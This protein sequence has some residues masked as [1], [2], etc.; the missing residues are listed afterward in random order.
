MIQSQIPITPEQVNAVTQRLSFALTAPSYVLPQIRE[1]KTSGGY[2]SYGLDNLYPQWLTKMFYGS[3]LHNAITLRKRNEIVANGL[4][5]ISN[6]VKLTSFMN[7]ECNRK[8]QAFQEIYRKITLDY[9]IYGGFAL[10]VIYNKVG[11]K[12]AEL[13]YID[14]AKLRYDRDAEKIKYAKD[15]SQPRVKTITYDPYN[16]DDH[17]GNKIFIYN[18][19]LTR[20]WYAIP[21]YVG[22]LPYIE[23]QC[24]IANYN[25]QNIKNG[26]APSMLISIKSGIPTI[27]EQ[28][29][30]E[31]QFQEKFSGSSNAGKM[32]LDFSESDSPTTTITPID[33]NNAIERYLALQQATVDNI[34]TGHQITTPSL[35]GQMVAGKLG[36]GTEYAQGME[37]FQNTYVKPHQNILLGI[38]NKLLAINFRTC[39][40][41][42]NPLPPVGIVLSD[43]IVM[44]SQMSQ[45]EIR[46]L[47]K[48]YGLITS[49]EF[50]D[51]EKPIT[52]QDIMPRLD[53]TDK[54]IAE[55]PTGV[56]DASSNP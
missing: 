8:G 15:W 53:T 22:A 19:E 21:E 44:A 26:M 56:P 31:R 41:Q 25:L 10:Q 32:V 14:Y 20:D 43:Q 54:E 3:S 39:D 9:L 6:N 27:E 51:G 34:F 36:I 48:K 2:L 49:V 38:I 7:D 45:Q 55:G 28:A 42:I 35:F 13:Y 29:A 18:G 47:L 11:G 4:Y 23:A 46:I 24:E 40:L 30:I 37:I 17:T 16:A 1:V 33:Q 50:V 52:I 5:S 12:I